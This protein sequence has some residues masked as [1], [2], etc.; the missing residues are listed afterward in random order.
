MET[1]WSVGEIMKAVEQAGIA[2][3]TMIIFTADNG[4]SHYTGWDELIAAGHQPSGP[5]RGHKSNIWEG[6][7][8]VPFIVKWTNQIQPATQ[9][10]QLLCLTDIFATVHEL[11]KNELPPSNQ[12]EDSFSFLPVLRE[13]ANTDARNHLVSHS[14]N[15][16]FAYRNQEGWKVVYKLPE[17]NLKLSR[18]KPATVE[19]YNLETDIGET[20]NIIDDYPLIAEQLRNELMRIVKRGTSRKGND[21]ANDVEVNFEIIQMTRWAKE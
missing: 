12:G 10:D 16:E 7:H 6:G 19:L 1:D 13:G 11:L 4:H 20:K 21:Q 3:N 5:Y 18:G 17:K 9:S 2:E 14:V 15:G 8:R